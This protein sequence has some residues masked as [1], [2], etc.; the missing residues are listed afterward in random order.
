VG[1][2]LSITSSGTFTPAVATT[3]RV[4]A[5]AMEAGVAN[6]LVEAVLFRPTTW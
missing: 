6:E 3:E 1:T 5:R 2:Y 4:C